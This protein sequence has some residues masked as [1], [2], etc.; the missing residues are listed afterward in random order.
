MHARIINLRCHRH[1]CRCEILHLL[2]VEIQLT[3]LN[4][5]LGHVDF[6]APG[7]RRNE[8]GNEL[9]TQVLTLIQSVEYAFKIVEQR[10]RRLAHHIEHLVL[11]V[12]R[13]HFQS[14]AHMVA[15]QFL[16]ISAVHG[17]NAFVAG[18]V[19][20]QV[21]A[22]TAT[23][24]R[25][26]HLGQRI[27]SMIHVE[28]G[29]MVV[30]QVRAWLGV[31]AAG[32]H[33]FAAQIFIA[34]AHT[35]H[36]SRRSAK[37]GDVAF[38]TFHLR[39]S[40][41]LA[42][43]RLLAARGDKF[44]LMC[45]DGAE[46]TAAK[47]T[48]VHIHRKAYHVEGRNAFP[49]VARMRQTGIVKVE[50]AVDFSGGHR[51]EHRIHLYGALA[52]RLPQR[53]PFIAVRLLLNVLKVLRLQ[54]AVFQALLK[55]VEHNVILVGL[56]QCR[57]RLPHHGLFH[58]NN[59]AYFLA[60]VKASG[61]FEHRFFAHAVDNHID[62][63]IGHYRRAQAVLPVV[64]VRVSA[65]RSLNAAGNNGHVGIEA[66][67]NLGIDNGWIVGAHAVAAVG[68]VGVIATAATG[69]GVMVNHRI[70]S[71][72]RNTEEQPRSTE[73]LEVAQIVLP[74]RL[75]HNSHAIVPHLHQYAPN[76]GSTKRRVVNIGIARKQHDVHLVPTAKFHLLHRRRQPIGQLITRIIHLFAVF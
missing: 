45:R 39:H 5:Q 61:H 18:L 28:Q 38:E 43:N 23:N 47:A 71:A 31:Q 25:L 67:Q 72:G 62:R 76:H 68:R 53:G 57:E 65:Q 3:R 4:C 36:I 51:W 64:V 56:R 37:V 26:L 74:V 33:T 63:C 16:V 60:G 69:G 40:L 30:V 1:G 29:R 70:H 48:A 2:K 58:I 9:L 35:I 8:V 12:L 41:H 6:R 15:Y 14:T 24:K 75:R 49:L 50:R 22:H 19:H 42:Q 55:R 44:A 54:I 66:T 73:F 20:R 21:V 52:V 10:K 59:V 34:S 17:I 7:V 32:A 46:G 11:G 13:G 27:H